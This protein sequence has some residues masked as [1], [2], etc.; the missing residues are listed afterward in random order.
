M[1]S[2]AGS[3]PDV[4]GGHRL[5]AGR[6][7]D[8]VFDRGLAGVVDE[9]GGWSLLGPPTI[10]PGHEGDQRR[11]QVASPG[12]ESVLVAERTLLVGHPM[13]DLGVLQPAKAVGEEV[14]GNAEALVE[15]LEATDAPEQVPQDQQGPAVADGLEGAGERT[16]FLERGDQ[17]AGHDRTITVRCEL[18][19]TRKAIR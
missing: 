18:Q 5:V 6:A 15:A 9:Q 3:A 17:L 14:P 2:G 4:V 13:D 12:G 1:A 8:R 7:S 16:A 19:R 11:G 10:T